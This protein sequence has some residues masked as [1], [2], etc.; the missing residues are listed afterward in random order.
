MQRRSLKLAVAQSCKVN[1]SL[2]RRVMAELAPKQINAI[3]LTRWID[4]FPIWERSPVLGLV[5]TLAIFALAWLLRIIADPVLP[6]GF[7]YV[8]FFPA[9][10]IS[11]FLFGARLGVLSAILCGIVAWYYFIAPQKSFATT[12][13]EVALSF[14]VFVVATDVFLVNGMQAANKQ[15]IRERE[16]NR[17]LASAKEAMFLELEQQGIERQQA[18]SDLRASEIQTR[19]ATETAG[20]GLWQWHIPSGQLHWDKTMFDLYGIAPTPDGLMHYSDYLASLHHDDADNQNAVLQKTASDCGASEREFRILRRTDGTVRYLRAVEIARANSDGK[21]EWVVGTNLD[22]TDQHNRHSHVQM[23]MGEINHRAKNLLA[24]VMSVAR[25]T[26]G[27]SHGDFIKKFSARIQS[28]AAGQDVLVENE[29][30]GAE[31]GILARAQLSHFK[32]L[33]GNRITISGD[34]V[35][36]SP[37]AVQ[38]IGMALHELATNAS[39]YGALSNNTGCVAIDW[40]IVAGTP[41]RR[42]FMTWSESFGP[43]VLPPEHSGFGST[44]TGDV[45]RM[46]LVGDVTTD[47]S[48][49]GFSWRLDCPLEK[50]VESTA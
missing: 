17:Q 45:V 44:I 41:G 10:I 11:S 12:G 18:L 50:V 46:S 6:P 1:H 25:Q 21:T 35:T 32:D 34:P 37:P 3:R 7:P 48:P 14:Y 13:A 23:L 36:L 8:T 28:L 16:I 38:T 26:D 47:F 9:V 31:L 30:M 40:R 43:A 39:K 19:L 33:I 22:V 49:T 15:L 5:G 4:L 20:V 27:A 24:V 2:M 29:W 42:L